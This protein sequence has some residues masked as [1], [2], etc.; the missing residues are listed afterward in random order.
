M[1]AVFLKDLLMLRRDRGALFISIIVPILMITTI[2]EALHRNKDEVKMRVPVVDEDQGPVART[3]INLLAEHAEVLI[4]SRAEA[5]ALVRDRNQ[6]AAAIVFPEHVSKNYLQG[7]TVEILLLTD[8]ARNT[9]LEQIKVMLLLMD[10]RA[11]ALADPLAEER[12]ALREV[13]LTGNRSDITAFEQTVP[14]YSL[15]FVL[16]AVIFGTAMAMHDERGWGTLPRLL[17]APG[18]FTWILVGKLLVRILVGFGQLLLL[19]IFGHFAFGISLGPSPVALLLLA[20]A[21]VFPIVGLGMLAAGLASTREQTLPIGLG[22][23]LGFS[24]LGGLWWPPW[25]TPVWM[26]H[27][28]SVVFTSWAMQGLH[29]LMLRNRGLAAL[30][31]TTGVLAA[32]GLAFTAIGLLLFRVRYSAR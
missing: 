2:A 7:R 1:L 27:V 23:V 28:S 29:D 4:V 26:Q 10:N 22:F 8:P 17:I 20:L 12:M 24:C 15:M 32:N 16:L 19:L 21:I 31:L 25:V 3:F 9:E 11:A 18:G 14:G 30:P 6:V 5:E 13:S